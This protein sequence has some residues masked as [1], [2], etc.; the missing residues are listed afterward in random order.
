MQ[1]TIFESPPWACSGCAELCLLRKGV[2]S[3][4]FTEFGSVKVSYDSIYAHPY[5]GWGLL[6]TT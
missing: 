4:L 3:Q 1:S 6:N 2:E 5:N